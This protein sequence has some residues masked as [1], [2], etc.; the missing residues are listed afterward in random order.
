VEK[1]LKF[2]VYAFL[3]GDE[4]EGSENNLNSKDINIEDILKDSKK[5]SKNKKKEHTIRKLTF[6]VNETK[7]SGRN[8]ATKGNKS[9]EKKEKLN[10]NDPN[11]WEKV[12]PMNGYSPK[13]LSRKFRVKKAEIL[14][15]KEN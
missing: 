8:S 4:E 2:G 14:K 12:M 3:G 11:F 13:Q 1:L 9:G 15:T 10:V 5:D 7:D 6:N